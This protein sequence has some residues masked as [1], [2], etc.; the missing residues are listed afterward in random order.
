MIVNLPEGRSANSDITKA[1]ELLRH[2]KC[3]ASP[4]S[5]YR[6]SKINKE[7]P[8]FII[9]QLPQPVDC[10]QALSNAKLLSKKTE[11]KTVYIFKDRTATEQHAHKALV[12]EMKEQKRN[13]EDV[14]L[15][16]SK[17]NRRYILT[18]VDDRPSECKDEQSVS[19]VVNLPPLSSQLSTDK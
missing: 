3:S 17:I 16:G 8:R 2:V 4:V 18:P 5:V 9:A 6:V 11:Y 7:K 12:G 10:Q 13:G 14:I 19:L 1:N 15:C